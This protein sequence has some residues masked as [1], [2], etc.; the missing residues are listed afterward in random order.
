M[1]I[2]HFSATRHNS[3][4]CIPNVTDY[5]NKQT[6][7]SM[8]L[9]YCNTSNHR[10]IFEQSFHAGNQHEIEAWILHFSRRED[11]AKKEFRTEFGKIK[12]QEN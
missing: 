4:Y 7:G 9:S 6:N 12:T 8:V 11:E 1:K 2:N 5:E 10:S 3:T